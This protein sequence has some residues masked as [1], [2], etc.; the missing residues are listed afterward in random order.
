MTYDAA[1]RITELRLAVKRASALLG[2]YEYAHDPGYLDTARQLLAQA[3][4]P[5]R[6]PRIPNGQRDAED[7]NRQKREQQRRYRSK[8]QAKR[9]AEI[10]NGPDGYDD[11]AVGL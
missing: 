6:K 2:M 11:L 4:E 1:K 7:I 5:L 3:D 10:E 9:L 8:Q